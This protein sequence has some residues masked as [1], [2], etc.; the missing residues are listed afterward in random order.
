MIADRAAEAAILGSV[1][2]SPDSFDAA[3]GAGLALEHF[4]QPQH[5]SVW[6]AFSALVD[7][8]RPIDTTSVAGELSD[9]GEMERAGG[10]TFLAELAGR[11]PSVANLPAN[12]A[13]VRDRHRRRRMAD[14]AEALTRAC[15]SDSGTSDVL[16]EHEAL[17]LELHG[18]D[19]ESGPR[20]LAD[21]L[22]ETYDAIRQRHE[23]PDQAAGLPYG[24][25]DLDEMMG[26]L[27]R[28]D[29]TIVAARPTMG[30]SALSLNFATSAAYAGGRVALFQLE[31]GD[32]QLGE[33]LLVSDARVSATRMKS[34]TL[35]ADD[36]GPLLA[37]MERLQALPHVVV[38]P[39]PGIGAAEIRARC[40]TIARRWNGL[41]LVVM[42]YIQ[43]VTGE[44]GVPRE[45]QIA[46]VSRGL[47][48]IAKELDCTVI[49]LSQLNRKV[50]ERADKRPMM[51]DLRESGAIEQDADNILTVYR[52]EVYGKTPENSGTAEI[53]VIKHRHGRTGI[54]NVA[55]RGDHQR[56]E[57]LSAE[58]SSPSASRTR[59]FVGNHI[60]RGVRD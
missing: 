52:D 23:N 48:L 60:G 32:H 33:R 44:K 11:V 13:R 6:S 43:L 49:A 59:D 21:V 35:R 8:G 31:M 40:R 10:W 51:S 26:G 53:G 3:V 24:L 9:A 19:Y 27:H 7:S 34:G 1:L 18:D 36:H 4:S 14:A 50:E 30:K 39:T 38:D 41:D 56:F 46:G 45:Q 47:K 28:S 57:D 25:R 16:R 54:V 2:L 20:P 42:D 58:W 15:R 55:W 37:A 17:L 29:L 22:E 5:R 12:V